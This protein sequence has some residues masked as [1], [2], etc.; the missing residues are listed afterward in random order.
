MFVWRLLTYHRERHKD[1]DMTTD[2]VL[3]LDNIYAN[4]VIL[5]TPG[6]IIGHQVVCLG[7]LSGFIA[8]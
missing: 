3:P 2:A 4:L 8:F 5:A 7:H 1:R 6:R